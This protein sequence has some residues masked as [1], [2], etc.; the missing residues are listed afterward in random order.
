[1]MIAEVM[2]WCAMA[3]I[4][5]AY[6]GYPCTL[7]ALSL[8]KDRVVQNRSIIPRVSFIIA[9]HNEE[10]R[11][12]EKI[13]N[14]L[15]QDYPADRIEIIVASDCSTDRTDDIVRTY[16]PR[17]L[18][19]R[20]R[21][22][23]GKEA[24]QRLAV[25]TAVGNILI[26]S[27]VA[28]ALAAD[29][30]SNVV[31]NFA[32]PTVGCVSSVDRFVE[33]DGS[34][35]GEGAYV[36]YEM[37]LRSLE[38]RLNTL[39]GL[40]GSFFA[41]RREVCSRWS[42][43]DPSDFGTVLQAVQMGLRGVLDVHSVGYYRNIADD[44]REFQRKVRTVTRGLAALAS[45][46]TMLNPLRYGL[47]SWQLASHK[48]C[49]WLVPFAMII[50]AVSNLFLLARSSFY[51]AS[52]LIQCAFYAAAV[53]GWWTR[54]SMLRIPMFLLLANVGIFTAWLRCARGDRV[55]RWSPSQRLR[56]LPRVDTR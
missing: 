51:G 52:L 21:E 32:D 24:A 50:A 40:S 42:A 14:T 46:A 11:I 13:E 2:F 7:M 31:R 44:R 25:R 39:V 37:W 29:A 3:L 5:Y 17:V 19:V 41:A 1:M 54:A 55:D 16:S 23:R 15:A 48:L 33:A 34:L 10:Q 26:F 9:A 56:A 27:D 22:R 35:S 49:R 18:L 47:F 30:V 36:R 38:S 43:D 53:A 45:N 6:V 12:A 8:R 28:T 4:L 20:A